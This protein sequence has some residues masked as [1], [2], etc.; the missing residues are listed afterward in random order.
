MRYVHGKTQHNTTRPD[1][2]RHNTTRHDRAHTVVPLQGLVHGEVGGGGEPLGLGVLPL[3][4][5][6]LQHL[7]QASLP[8]A[9]DPALAA[10]PAE[11]SERDAVGYGNLVGTK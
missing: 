9:R 10:V 1:M 4:G 7:E 8:A 11:A 5:L 3:L 6:Q 2:T